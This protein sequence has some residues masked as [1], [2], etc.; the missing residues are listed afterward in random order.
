MAGRTKPIDGARLRRVLKSNGYNLT[1]AGEKIGRSAGC[2]SQGIKRGMLGTMTVDAIEKN[3]G[4]EYD[5]YKPLREY[6]PF[7]EPPKQVA[8]TNVNEAQYK[9]LIRMVAQV[10]NNQQAIFELLKG[11]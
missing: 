9:T 1:E 4:I 11:E 2:L 6:D 8:V 7:N 3:L 5:R 10:L